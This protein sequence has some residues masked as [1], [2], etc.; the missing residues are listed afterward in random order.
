MNILDV[1]IIMQSLTILPTTTV[2]PSFGFPPEITKSQA[3]KTHFK[4]MI[5]ISFPENDIKK[6]Q[7]CM[8]NTFVYFILVYMYEENDLFL[9]LSKITKDIKISYIPVCNNS[10]ITVPCSFGKTGKGAGTGTKRQKIVFKTN[11]CVLRI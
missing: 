10:G 2:P 8:R 6:L 4:S 9:D 1:K 11:I 3:I 5:F 7:N